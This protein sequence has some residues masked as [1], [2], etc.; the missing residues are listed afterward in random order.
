MGRGG[1]GERRG[2]GGEAAGE[3]GGGTR[4][5]LDQLV[6]SRSPM[7]AEALEPGGGEAAILDEAVA[8]L[9]FE[10]GQNLPRLHPQPP[11]STLLPA[12]PPMRGGVL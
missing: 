10:W 6:S 9:H 7:G 2:A 5:P 12:A 3:A 4:L 11:L 8:W 1:E